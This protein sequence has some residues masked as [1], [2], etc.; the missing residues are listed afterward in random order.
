MSNLPPSLRNL[1]LRRDRNL[2]PDS[3]L[4]PAY[5]VPNSA[6]N[7]LRGVRA[8]RLRCKVPSYRLLPSLVEVNTCSKKTR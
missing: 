1:Y 7:A 6:E 8:F 4:T 2:Y 3:Y 5:T